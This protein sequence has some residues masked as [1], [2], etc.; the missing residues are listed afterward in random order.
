MRTHSRNSGTTKATWSPRRSNSDTAALWHTT[1]E[2]RDGDVSITVIAADF[3]DGLEE[4]V[5]YAQADAA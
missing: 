2:R 4:L 5:R 3:D 1:I